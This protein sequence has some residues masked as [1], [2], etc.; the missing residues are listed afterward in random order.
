MPKKAMIKTEE[1]TEDIGCLL[2]RSRQ[3]R[4]IV[5]TEPTE[6]EPISCPESNTESEPKSEMSEN[7]S[8]SQATG[9]KPKTTS[10]VDVA[11]KKMYNAFKYRLRSAPEE[12]QNKWTQLQ[13][14]SETIGFDKLIEF[15]STV[16]HTKKNDYDEQFLS[17]C[18]EV[19][20]EESVGKDGEWMPYKQAEGIEGAE[21]LNEMIQA[22]TVTTRRHPRLPENSKIP[23][24]YNQQVAYVKETWSKKRRVVDTHT[25]SEN[26]EATTANIESF[27]GDF[28]RESGAA[29]S[30]MRVPVTKP[31]TAGTKQKVDDQQVD[32]DTLKVAVTSLRKG[33]SSWDRMK[34]DWLAVICKS[35]NHQNT[36]GCKFESDLKHLMEH[37]D[38]LD[39]K[40]CAM[41]GKHLTGVKLNADD[42]KE[43]SAM[44]N[45]L[46]TIIKNGSKKANALKPWFIVD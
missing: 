12:V 32:A 36:R 13:S 42:I 11:G 24:P 43:S 45:E 27:M 10:I 26:A 44:T 39:K 17:S 1:N 25:L 37:G 22:G 4:P 40:I 46:A 38:K 5:K 3:T 2:Q 29:S 7:D 20:E 9:Q 8:A 35:E 41:E 18:R 30:D 31:I 34:R 19:K 23:Y 16:A 28:N 33:H 14:G 21:A 15:M 6:L